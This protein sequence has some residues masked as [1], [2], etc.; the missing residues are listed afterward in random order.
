MARTKV[1]E[2][3]HRPLAGR[4]PH[5]RLGPERRPGVGAGAARGPARRGLHPAKLG[6][7]RR[8]PALGETA[9][10]GPDVHQ[11]D[12][13]VAP[14]APGH[15]GRVPVGPTEPD[16]HAV[17]EVKRRSRARA[18][19]LADRA[20]RRL[21][22]RDPLVVAARHAAHGGGRRRADDSPNAPTVRRFR[23]VSRSAS[24]TPSGV[25]RPRQ[26]PDLGR[27]GPP[28]ASLPRSASRTPSGATR[29]GGLGRRGDAGPGTALW[30]VGRPFDGPSARPHHHRADNGKDF[31]RKRRWTAGF[32]SNSGAGRR[33]T[34]RWAVG[35][36]RARRARE[37]APGTDAHNGPAALR[38][39]GARQAGG[40]SGSRNLMR[41]PPPSAG[42]AV[43]S[44]PCAS[45]MRRTI[46][47]PRPEPGMPR[48]DGAR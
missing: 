2:D 36:G 17:G 48:A 27:T 38:P 24:R 25:R 18:G 13:Q 14:R 21:P 31:S 45:A 42:S 34:K 40:A 46:A 11:A 1:G 37:T 20:R 39:P 12:D 29:R 23:S 16:P 28:S 47:R 6:V 5:L 44:P 7:E 41:V 26:R 15:E 35:P 30:A 10:G 33:A 19:S 4:E 32:P 43:T 8:V 22:E 9:R 3:R